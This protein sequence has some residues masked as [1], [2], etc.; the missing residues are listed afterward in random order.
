MT[1]IRIRIFPRHIKHGRAMSELRCPAALAINEVTRRNPE[2][3][4]L[5]V[6]RVDNNRVNWFAVGKHACLSKR[7]QKWIDRFD[8]PTPRKV[9]PITFTLRI[10]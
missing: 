1:F 2:L 9:K 10:R 4:R 8:S 3:H 5:D 6:A 7:M